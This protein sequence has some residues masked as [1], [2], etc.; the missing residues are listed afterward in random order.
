[1]S[2]LKLCIF[3]IFIFFLFSSSSNCQA[4]KNLTEVSAD[5]VVIN[6]I[7]EGAD[8]YIDG[9]FIGQTPVEVNN[10]P[11]K[12]YSVKIKKEG[13]KDWG[14]NFV[15]R[16]DFRREIIAV[17]DGTYGLLTVQSEP[18]G[19]DVFIDDSLMGK[20]PILHMKLSTKPH[21]VKLKKT[22]YSEWG[23]VINMTSNL[24]NL[25]A[26]LTCLNSSVSFLN[27]PPT[28]DLIVDAQK[29]DSSAYINKLLVKGTH[30]IELLDKRTSKNISDEIETDPDYTYRVS[31]RYNDFTLAPLGYS[32]FLPGAGQFYNG[33]YIKGVSIFAGALISG[34]LV[35]SSSD[36]YNKKLQIY[37]DALQRYAN[38][39][40][41]S[42][43]VFS[44]SVVLSAQSDAKSALNI[45]R[46]SIG[47][48]IGIYV[49]N[50]LDALIFESRTDHLEI[51]KTKVDLLSG[52]ALLGYDQEIKIKFGIPI[53]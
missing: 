5:P 36:N 39:S 26:R 6:S 25:Q 50:L 13:F 21:A 7:P 20:T 44:R 1:M 22:G 23:T 43:A 29:I 42:D 41:E 11:K 38:A 16:G 14:Y 31:A 37:N 30:S 4:N 49:Y 35:Y 17:L 3:L 8:V 24:E 12:P 34:Y 2:Y 52:S 40:N 33:S 51:Y 53:K 19:A 18:E 28:A 27:I 47:A 46:I 32:F 15:Y 9:E 45:K 48:L 10:F